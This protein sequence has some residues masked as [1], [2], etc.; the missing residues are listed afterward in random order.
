MRQKKKEGILKTK[1]ETRNK[2]EFKLFMYRYIYK[3]KRHS[4]LI[5][6]AFLPS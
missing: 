1:E 4:S 2:K 3:F 5:A 6:S